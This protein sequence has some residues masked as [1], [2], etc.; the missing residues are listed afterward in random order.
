M[1]TLER[2]RCA[3]R[4]SA[5]ERID[6]WAAGSATFG[7]AVWAGMAVLA[8]MEVARIGATELLFLFAPLV[9]VPLGTELARQ[10]GDRG[11][12][13]EVARR[14]L[15]VGAVL[16]V[17]AT[18][19]APGRAAAWVACGWLVVCVVM[20]GDG[21][22]RIGSLVWGVAGAGTRAKRAQIIVG[23]AKMDLA[24]GGAWFV[25]SRLGMR[26][27]RIQEPIG[28]LTAVHF[29]YAG[30][31]TAMIGAAML[32]FAERNRQAIRLPSIENYPS[33][34]LRASSGWGSRLVLV[35]AGLPYLVAAGFVISPAVKMGAA[36]LFSIS[37]GALAVCL[38]D[39]SRQVDDRLVRVL[40][41]IASV[42]VVG[43]MVLAGIYAVADFF[44]SEVLTIPQMAKTHGLMDTFGFCLV[45]LLGWIVEGSSRG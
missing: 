34:P 42:A 16:A 41:Q 26:P 9:I 11:R 37:V 21:V 32:G 3:E 36:I 23:I 14:M 19:L 39:M 43:G 25:A 30:F 12:F 7:A 38:H 31:A 27:W 20:A 24:V 18:C 1:K 13:G 10:L 35:V 45:G 15:P 8:R 28:L 6:F 22:G 40:L 29:H 5:R 44:G 33:A 2:D 17:A 4:L